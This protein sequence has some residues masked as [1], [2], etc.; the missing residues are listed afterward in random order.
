MGLDL[1]GQLGFQVSKAGVIIQ[2]VHIVRE[3]CQV[4]SPSPT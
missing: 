2:S 3:N 4:C 1:F